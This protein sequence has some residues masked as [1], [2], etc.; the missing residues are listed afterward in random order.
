MERENEIEE[1]IYL[2]KYVEYEIKK[3]NKESY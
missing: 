3:D 1:L 2:G